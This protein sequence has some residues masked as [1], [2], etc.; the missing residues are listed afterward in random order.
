MALEAQQRSLV[1]AS[2]SPGS[3]AAAVAGRT[4]YSVRA[5][6]RRRTVALALGL[7]VA[8]AMAAGTYLLLS[9]SSSASRGAPPGHAHGAPARLSPESSPRP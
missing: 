6:R 7:L 1:A 3:P 8:L 2:A 4:N 9:G 5:D